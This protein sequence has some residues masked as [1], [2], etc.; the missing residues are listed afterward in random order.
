MVEWRV[1]NQ[2]FEDYTCPCRQGTDY[3][4]VPSASWY[5]WPNPCPLAGGQTTDLVG[6]V[7]FLLCSVLLLRTL[8]C[9][10]QVIRSG[11]TWS[12]RFHIILGQ[13]YF[14]CF[15]TRLSTYPDVLSNIEVP[16][17]WIGNL[18]VICEISFSSTLIH[19]IIKI[20]KQQAKGDL[21]SHQ[22]PG[23]RRNAPYTSAWGWGFQIPST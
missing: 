10:L 1:K 3:L 6:G 9:S 5:T 16:P 2:V 12:H 17:N 19:G 7:K 8:T 23:F 4:R 20:L 21:S 15:F 18:S 14:N 13:V 11:S 22:T